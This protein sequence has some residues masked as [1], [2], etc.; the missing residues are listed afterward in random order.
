MERG[1]SGLRWFLDLAEACGRLGK[2]LRRL[3]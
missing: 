2:L 3:C 1:A